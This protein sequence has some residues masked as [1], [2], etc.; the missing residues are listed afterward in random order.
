MKL[1]VATSSTI[2]QAATFIRAGGLVAFPTETVYG[3]G[4]DALNPMAVAKIFEVKNRP[5]F[6]PLI[7]HIADVSLMEKLC[8][9]GDERARKLIDRFWPGP[10]TLVLP[11]SEIV[12]EIVTAGLPT[13]ALR[14]PAHPVALALIREAGTPVAAP[15][16]NPF[17]YLS[18]TTAEHVKEQLGEKVDMILDGGP[19]QVGVESTIINLSQ[20]E[21]VLLRPG[22]LPLE[23]IEQTIGK[24]RIAATDSSRPQAPG[25]LPR[26]Y[27]PR[28][29]LRILMG[30]TPRIPEGKRVG[31]LAFRHPSENL[32]YERIEVLSPAGD[33]KEAAVN[34][35]ACLHKLDR[36]GLDVI[37]A[38]PVP[39]VGLGR[40][41]MDR[42]MKAAAGT[43][44]CLEP[45]D[46][47]GW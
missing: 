22:G 7:V 14:M 16:A 45:C 19:C 35:F 27:S 47:T 26:H 37:Y 9:L 28:T 44:N 15:S 12:P 17:G 21:A 23:Q 32:P 43:D 2:H 6:D 41:I 34:L 18:P 8:T 42:L 20:P 13:V 38:E 36:A 4:A 25:Q 24:V 29:P 1:V 30:D 5:R 31:L 3:L 11:K 33:L 39:A 40:A 10:L 46:L